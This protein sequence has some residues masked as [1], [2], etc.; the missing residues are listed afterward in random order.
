M[1]ES[2][3]QVSLHCHNHVGLQIARAVDYIDISA[4]LFWLVACV[5]G[6]YRLGVGLSKLYDDAGFRNFRTHLRI[7]LGAVH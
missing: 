2:M 3:G 4:W 1:P 7:T 6:G 5:N